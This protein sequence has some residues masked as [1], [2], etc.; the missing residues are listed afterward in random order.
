MGRQFNRLDRWM[1]G[2]VTM[3]HIITK[4][5]L[6]VENGIMQPNTVAEDVATYALLLVY[7]H[8]IVGLSES[9]Y[10]YRKDRKGNL[11]S[12][13][14]SYQESVYVMENIVQSFRD[15]GIYFQYRKELM[16][17]LRRWISRALSPLLS[18]AEEDIYLQS[19]KNGLEVYSRCFEGE[20]LP[21]E[22]LWGS[23]NLT[24]IVNKLNLLEDPYSR[25][26]F[27]SMIAVMPHRQQEYI[28]EHKN[29]YRKYMLEREFSGSFQ[30][31]LREQKPE[32]FFFDLLEERHDIICTE[33]GYYTKS[34]AY[35]E[36][37]MSIGD[38][39]IISRDSDE[40]TELWKE[41]C[42]YF[43]SLVLS[44]VEPQKIYM[45]ENYLAERHGDG[46]VIK[47]FEDIETIQKT[48]RI[49]NSYYSYIS[50]NYPEIRCVK[51]YEVDKYY[52]DDEYEYG[53]YPWHLNE[54]ANIQIAEN[55]SKYIVKK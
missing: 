34:D 9:L 4:K 12:Q 5:E 29:V 33:A 53:C 26:Q 30:R 27:S 28:I 49:L 51:A 14:D 54:W 22:L 23:F 52:T 32:Y 37:T 35:D 44:V 20:I 43:M 36:A 41:S 15:R 17:Y 25:F 8:K 21:S 46:T 7:A 6:W 10:Y 55:M 24:R 38:Y 39:I 31:I 47:K 1:L 19:R 16:I 50:R 13:S 3:W 48:N 11:C 42:K 45:V 40:C 18:Q 2:N